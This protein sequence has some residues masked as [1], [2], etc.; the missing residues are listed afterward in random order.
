MDRIGAP[1]Q[2]PSYTG[3]GILGLA[4]N[5]DMLQQEEDAQLQEQKDS[6]NDPL[7]I[8]LSSYVDKCWQAAQIAKQEIQTRLERCLRQR[9]GEYDPEKLTEIQKQGGSEIYIRL[10]DT[11]CRAAESWMKDILFPAGERPWKIDPTPIPD[12]PDEV[13]ALIEEKVRRELW[14][15][16]TS[17][18]VDDVSPGAIQDRVK[19]LGDD[20]KKDMQERAQLDA[21][22]LTDDV[23]DELV[24]GGWYAALK[25]VIT[26]IIDYPTG[27]IKGPVVRRKKKLEWSDGR[28]GMPPGPRVVTKAQRRYYRVSPFDLYPSPGARSVDDGYLIEKMRLRRRDLLDLIGVAGFSESAIRQVIDEYGRGGLRDWLIGDTTRAE[29]EDRPHERDDPEGS[30]D[31]LEFNGSCMGSQIIEWGATVKPTG[32]DVQNF[33][34]TEDYQVAL[35]KIGSYVIGVKINP[36]PLGKR[37]YYAASFDIQND[38]VWGRSVPEIIRDIQDSINA[39]IRAMINNL[40][41]SS[42]PQVWY[43][44]DRIPDGVSVED[45]HPWKYWPFESDKTGT[46]DRLPMGFFQPNSNV[47]ELWVTAKEFMDLAHTIAGIPPYTYGSGD[48]GGAARTASGLSMLMNSASKG[49]KMVIGHIDDG[50][51]KP[52]VTEHHTHIMLFDPSKARGDVQIRARASDY[53]IMMEQLQIRLTELLGMLNNPVDQKI[54]GEEGRADLLREIFRVHKIPVDVVPDDEE[55]K[56]RRQREVEYVLQTIAQAFGVPPQLLMQVLETGAVPGAP[57][58][59]IPAPTETDV[60]G[61]QMGGRDHAQFA[62]G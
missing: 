3:K 52:S 40:A 48:V 37:Y 23:D 33:E 8:G 53:L 46:G 17:G 62:K 14:D 9:R 32:M 61:N 1:R 16:I 47:T 29:L 18:A 39:T 20:I 42:G 54:I 43:M 15:M 55:L 56:A 50:M 36:H 2:L 21:D 49:L 4:S 19:R 27:F 30:I 38:S 41:L 28:N 5:E 44:I 12:L 11:I 51:I 7:V 13:H 45:M 6:Q 35:W 25:Q 22:E 31:C 10:T 34:A 59:Q 57:P 24:E 26:D 58:K 60:A